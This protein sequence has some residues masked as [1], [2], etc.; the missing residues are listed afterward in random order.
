M[1]GNGLD[2][3]VLRVKWK[4]ELLHVSYEFLPYVYVPCLPALLPTTA[5]VV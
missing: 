1:T 2:W 3:T 4:L 5:F